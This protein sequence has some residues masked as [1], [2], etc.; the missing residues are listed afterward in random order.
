M[1]I[2]EKI[3]NKNLALKTVPFLVGNIGP[4]C[5]SPCKV[6]DKFEPPKT[7]THWMDI[8]NE[9]DADLFFDKRIASETTN[10]SEEKLT[11][12]LGYYVHLI[13]DI[14]WDKVIKSQERNRPLYD[15]FNR[16]KIAIM[17][18]KKDWEYQD[19]LYLSKFKGSVFHKV[20]KHIEAFP[21]YLDYYPKNAITARINYI[22]DFYNSFEGDPDREDKYLKEKDLSRFVDDISDLIF[23][24]NVRFKEIC[25][26]LIGL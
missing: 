11:F 21:D 8:H 18:I 6:T 4:D 25:G 15:K 17:E 3:L 2:A 20:F 5:S 23:Y 10:C 9:I 14:E 13:V 22:A 1:R 19:H 7:I 24:Q 26:V 16:D 12:L